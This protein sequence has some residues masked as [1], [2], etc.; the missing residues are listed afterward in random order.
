MPKTPR[1]VNLD[2]DLH[3]RAH[4]VLDRLPGNPSLSGLLNEL[5]GGMLP[6]LEEV[7]DVY[8]RE[9]AEAVEEVIMRSVGRVLLVGVTSQD[10]EE[11]GT[12]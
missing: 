3:A 2:D 10:R 12:T 5:L 1:T 8:S 4:A 6:V 11:V 7:A 9:G